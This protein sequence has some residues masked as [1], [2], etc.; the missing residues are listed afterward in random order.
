M[1]AVEVCS[2]TPPGWLGLA[3]RTRPRLQPE[4]EWA[5]GILAW[6]MQKGCRWLSG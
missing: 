5:G 2:T 3:S 6:D 4:T 1:T